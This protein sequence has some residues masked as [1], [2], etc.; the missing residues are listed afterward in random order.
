MGRARA[1]VVLLKRS[2]VAR[3]RAQVLAAVCIVACG[4]TSPTAN[5]PDTSVPGLVR[6]LADAGGDG[7]KEV[8]LSELWTRA[9]EGTDEDLMR[10]AATLGPEGLAD[11]ATTK[12]A[13]GV[14]VRAMAYTEGFAGLPWLSELA[15]GE[16]VTLAKEAGESALTMAARGRDQNDP[17]D[18][19][20]MRAGC[21]KLLAVAK[22]KHDKAVRILAVRT[23]R[24]LAD[25]G[26]AKADEIPTDFD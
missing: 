20:E 25:R 7:G 5:A 6:P 21:M 4:R 10:L 9:S 2:K 26:C 22:G 8:A 3:A 23:V 15:A 17:E 1:L 18:A 14:A 19:E 11:G 24:L 12:E 13:R 16:D